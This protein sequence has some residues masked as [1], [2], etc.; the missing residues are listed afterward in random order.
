MSVF[1]SIQAILKRI[2]PIPSTLTHQRWISSLRRIHRMPQQNQP[3]LTPSPTRCLSIL[4]H[5]HVRLISTMKSWKRMLDKLEIGAVDVNDSTCMDDLQKYLQFITCYQ[6]HHHRKEDILF[7]IAIDS[8]A[9]DYDVSNLIIETTKTEHLESEGVERMKEIHDSI[10]EHNIS[11]I[12]KQSK[13]FINEMILHIKEENAIIFP[14]I[15]KQLK[16]SEMEQSSQILE[17]QDMEHS[18]IIN[19]MELLSDELTQKY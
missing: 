2:H 5:E 6:G 13:M 11:D 4:K 8:C 16:E 17:K 14:N 12:I 7:D 1:R 19:A 10:D 18:G 15:A 9:L 3:T